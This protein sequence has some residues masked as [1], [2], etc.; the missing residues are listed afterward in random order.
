MS[1]TP[2]QPGDR[3]RFVEGWQDL[4]IYRG[5]VDIEY[6]TIQSLCRIIDLSQQAVEQ[7][8]HSYR[9]FKTG[10]AIL[11]LDEPGHRTG[12]YFG[13]NYTPYKGADWNCAEKRALRTVQARGFTN[14]L[15]IAVSGP[16]QIDESGVKSPTLHPCYKCRAMFEQS[17]LFSPDAFIATATPD[18]SAHELHTLESLLA[19]HATHEPQPFPVGHQLLP[20]YWKQ[21]LDFDAAEEKAEVARLAAIASISNQRLAQP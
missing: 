4:N 5:P 18:G 20:F 12:I 8:G 9:G 16:L 3:P 13:G 17:D 6:L 19:L 1:K 21:I 2:L 14:V 10:A 7:L 15:A 11:A